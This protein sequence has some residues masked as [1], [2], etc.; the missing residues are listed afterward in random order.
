MTNLL[1][2]Q[3]AMRSEFCTQLNYLGT[4]EYSITSLV[5]KFG[6]SD[7]LIVPNDII[8]NILT[9][10]K[11]LGVL[12]DNKLTTKYIQNLPLFDGLLMYFQPRQR[13]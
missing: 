7:I 11:D 13:P 12:I 2:N 1:L 3:V 6:A 9:L 10:K 4:W 8:N 5:W